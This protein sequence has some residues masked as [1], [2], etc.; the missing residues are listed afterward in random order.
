MSKKQNNKQRPA[1]DL[2]P[3]D[4]CNWWNPTGID[5]LSG[6]AI[7]GHP[8]AERM[9]AR[10]DPGRW[11]RREYGVNANLAWLCDNYYQEYTR[12]VEAGRPKTKPFVSLALTTEQQSKAWKVIGDILRGAAKPMPAGDDAI[13]FTTRKDYNNE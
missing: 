10:K 12:W 2:P 5:E 11:N 8:D 3:V 6:A 4:F 9:W 13:D 7:G 1:R